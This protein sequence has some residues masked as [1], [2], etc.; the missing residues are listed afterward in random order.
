MWG[1]IR[2]PFKEAGT[3]FNA[4]PHLLKSLV[5]SQVDTIA[6]LVFLVGGFSLQILGALKVALHEIWILGLWIILSAMILVY[7]SGARKII[8]EKR[9]KK[10]YPGETENK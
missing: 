1:E 2:T 6:G 5:K 10:M 4:N 8:I 7:I 3:Y 9:L